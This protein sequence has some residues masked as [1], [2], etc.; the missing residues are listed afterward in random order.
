MFPLDLDYSRR[1]PERSPTL[2]PRAGSSELSPRKRSAPRSLL[3]LGCRRGSATSSFASTALS[4]WCL[5]GATT[6]RLLEC[7]QE[8]VFYFFLRLTVFSWAAQRYL[9]E[10]CGRDGL[11]DSLGRPKF[12]RTH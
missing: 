10:R 1:S 11:V 4:P 12:E 2:G 6:K 3:L 9:R 8:D 5:G 7:R